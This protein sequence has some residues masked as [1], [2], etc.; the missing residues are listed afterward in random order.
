MM[1]KILECVP[2]FSEGRDQRK[3]K[4]ISDSI[5]SVQGVQLLHIDIGVAVNRTVITF[6]GNPS[7][8]VE[9]A[10]RA[11]ETASEVIDMRDHLGTHPRMGATDVC[12]LIPLKDMTMEEAVSCSQKLAERVGNE[13]NVPVYLYERSATAPHRQN[14][15]MVRKGGYEGMEHKMQQKKW[16]PDYGPSKF[17]DKSGVTAIGARKLLVAYNIN[18]N[19]KSVA[20]AHD[21][22]Y[23][24]RES[25]KFVID[26]ETGEMTRD[27]EGKAE[28]IPGTL[29]A[30]KAIGWYIEEYKRA[31]ISS[32]LTDIKQTP[33][34]VVFEE[35]ER[36]ASA[37]GLRVTGSEIVGMVPKIV[38][39]EAGKHFLRKQHD[40][41]NYD[42]AELMEIAI[43][44]LGLND[45]VKFDP[46][47]KVLEYLLG[48]DQID[49]VG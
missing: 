8:V 25:G 31:Q 40:Y 47:L 30:V 36:L 4:A 35:V 17:N 12:P 48:I 46:E 9:A 5:E 20:K 27:A 19:T 28:R 24:I 42:E 22:A 13:L 16:F 33:L 26:P 44:S 43:I 2:N 34:H 1:Q 15:A 38:L 29:K 7:S 23:E 45:V 3:I 32:N 21:I 41:A 39:V 10:F 6:A 37:L 18:L 49:L 11:I 14:L